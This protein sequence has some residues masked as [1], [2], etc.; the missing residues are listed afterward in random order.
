MLRG[1]LD[2]AERLITAVLP[3]SD[4]A[5]VNVRERLIQAAQEAIA[6]EW[7][8]FQSDLGPPF[9]VTAPNPDSMEAKK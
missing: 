4:A 7:K 9:A 5:T 1:R 3:D 6:T 8:K 2:G